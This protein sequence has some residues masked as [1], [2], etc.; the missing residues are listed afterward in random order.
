MDPLLTLLG[1]LG[2]GLATN[3][4]YELLKS[5]ADKPISRA[6]L[7][8]ELQNRINLHGVTMQADTVISALAKNGYLSIQGSDIYASKALVFGSERGGAIVGEDSKLRTDRTATLAGPGAYVETQ[9]NAQVSHNPDGSISFHV[10]EDGSI[11][12]KTN[13]DGSIDF[14]TKT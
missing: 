1:Q 3:A 11:A 13:E 9:G 12:F 4:I 6:A 14:K 8:K 2:L 7:E 10:G 5:F